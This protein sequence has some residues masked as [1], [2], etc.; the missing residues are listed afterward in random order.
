MGKTSRLRWIS[1]VLLLVLVGVAGLGWVGRTSLLSWYYV[2][3]LTLA[4][5]TDRE[6]WAQNVAS[7]DE[8]ALPRLLDA[9]AQD[10]TRV[11]LNV[12]TALA[13]LTDRWHADPDR[14]ARL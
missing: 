13:A 3:G 1:G 2:R 9:L 5:E 4:G 7:L 8:A 12:Q 6:S 14:Q 11:C 10:D